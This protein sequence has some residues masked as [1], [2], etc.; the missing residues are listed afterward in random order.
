MM[1]K[2][3]LFFCTVIVVG[4]MSACEISSQNTTT[5]AKIQN[6]LINTNWKG[7]Y[8]GAP[9]HLSEEGQLTIWKLDGTWTR[10]DNNI[11]VF[12][13]DDNGNNIEKTF[14]ITEEDGATVLKPK[15]QVKNGE[16]ATSY[17]TDIYY[18]E[19]D[20]EAARSKTV[21]HCGDTV[22]TDVIDFTLHSAEFSYYTSSMTNNYAMPVPNNDVFTF[23]T[24]TGRTFVCMTFTIKSKDRGTIDVGGIFGDWTLNFNALYGGESYEIKGFDLNDKNGSHGINLA[25]A[26]F[27]Y[28]GGKTFKENITANTLLRAGKTVTIR[29]FGVITVDPKDVKDV[30][31]LKINVLN[32][33]GENEYFI[34]EIK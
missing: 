27:S 21:K 20:Y 10:N 33:D 5:S 11:E 1:K 16:I 17:A 14:E 8:Y 15:I 18:L 30:F 13:T 22:S 34:Y 4:F 3:L 9:I 28:D 29:T 24:N 31:D 32:S 2:I 23:T 25:Y 12:F 19:G 7:L 26:A 6:E